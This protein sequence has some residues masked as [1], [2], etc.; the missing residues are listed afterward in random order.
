MVDVLTPS[1]ELHGQRIAA[2]LGD[3]EVPPWVVTDTMALHAYAS[4]LGGIAV[5]EMVKAARELGGEEFEEEAR[6]SLSHQPP[7]LRPGLT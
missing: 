3:K 2:R 6:A 4:R 5:H 7:D 1:R